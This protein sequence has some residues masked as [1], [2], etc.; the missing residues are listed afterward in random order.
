MLVSTL[1]VATGMAGAL[2]IAAMIQST[3]RAGR[4]TRLPELRCD[5]RLRAVRRRGAAEHRRELAYRRRRQLKRR[6]ARRTTAA[7]P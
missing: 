6:V 5:P 7:R 2:V 1:M 4:A 3:V